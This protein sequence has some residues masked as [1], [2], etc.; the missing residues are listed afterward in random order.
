[1]LFCS[2]VDCPHWQH[3]LTACMINS[4]VGI[5]RDRRQ[6]FWFENIFPL[7]TSIEERANVLCDKSRAVLFYDN[8]KIDEFFKKDAQKARHKHLK[9]NAEALETCSINNSIVMKR[10]CCCCCC[11]SAWAFNLWH[12]HTERE[13]DVQRDTATNNCAHKLCIVMV[14]DWPPTENSR[15]SQHAVAACFTAVDHFQSSIDS[16]VCCLE[17]SENIKHTSPTLQKP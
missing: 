17:S 8:D 15:I 3:C 16:K 5:R 2:L 7:V 11:C 14:T 4:S 1:M 10:Y 12:Q 13:K 9:K 6:S